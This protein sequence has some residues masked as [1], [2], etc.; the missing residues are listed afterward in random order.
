MRP[1]SVV[2]VVWGFLFA[3]GKAQVPVFDSNQNIYLDNS[4]T[5]EIDLLLFQEYINLLCVSYNGEVYLLTGIDPAPLCEKRDNKYLKILLF[6]LL[7]KPMKDIL[8]E[9]M[10]DLT[11]DPPAPITTTPPVTPA[12]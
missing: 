2:F 6:F 9:I 11:P 7:F 12:G 4:S 10:D 5:S 1:L 3:L 8:E